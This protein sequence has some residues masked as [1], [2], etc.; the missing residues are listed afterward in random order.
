MGC[1]TMSGERR[2]CNVCEVRLRWVSPTTGRR[3]TMCRTCAA[4]Y[5]K[6][7][8]IR[9]RVINPHITAVESLRRRLRGEG[10]D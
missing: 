7:L 3:A 8:V 9:Q 6:E 5:R 1:W 10:G 2:Y 4:E